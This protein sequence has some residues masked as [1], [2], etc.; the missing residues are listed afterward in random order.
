[1]EEKFQNKIKNTKNFKVF[2][3][4]NYHLVLFYQNTMSS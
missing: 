3:Y 4:V 2:N 1:M